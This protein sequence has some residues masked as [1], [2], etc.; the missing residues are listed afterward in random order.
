[1]S[2]PSASDLLPSSDQENEDMWISPLAAIL[3]IPA[4]W[5]WGDAMPEAPRQG[6]E[7]L[8]VL[9]SPLRPPITSCKF[10]SHG[11]L[12]HFPTVASGF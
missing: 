1:M 9:R 6:S 8:E 4:G 11:Y 7:D 12:G 5:G 2:D 3:A 10:F